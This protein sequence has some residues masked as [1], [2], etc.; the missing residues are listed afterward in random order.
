M[1][2]NIYYT[3]WENRIKFDNLDIIP[4]HAVLTLGCLCYQIIALND[5]IQTAVI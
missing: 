5:D 3:K 4:I 1:Y 2:L